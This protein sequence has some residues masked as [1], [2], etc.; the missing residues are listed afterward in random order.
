MARGPGAKRRYVSAGGASHPCPPLTFPFAVILGSPGLA[1]LQGERRRCVLTQRL[2]APELRPLRPGVEGPSPAQ[3]HNPG[4][5][6]LFS[7]E[8]VSSLLSL[9]LSLTPFSLSLSRLASS[10]LFL[11]TVSISPSPPILPF[12]RTFSGSL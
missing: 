9:S 8:L 12:S 2:T 5:L 6:W 7:P 1:G 11:D 3:R 4:Q 10:S